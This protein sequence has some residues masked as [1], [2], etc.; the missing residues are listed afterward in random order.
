[1]IAYCENN[2]DDDD[3]WLMYVR[4]FNVINDDDED[5]IVVYV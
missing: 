3:D 5:C 1:M 4:D 2:D